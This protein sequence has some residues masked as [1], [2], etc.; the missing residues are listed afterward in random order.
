MYLFPMPIPSLHPGA[1]SKSSA[2]WCS[3]KPYQAWQNYLLKGISPPPAPKN[4]T[5]PIANNMELG[6][7]L[8][9]RGTP[10]MIG[11]D[12]IIKPGV[13]PKNP[14]KAINSWLTEVNK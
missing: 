3:Q 12:G 10:A 4:C 7:R 6:N 8:G 9:V 1:V 5:S 14:A 2:I 13:P 11:P